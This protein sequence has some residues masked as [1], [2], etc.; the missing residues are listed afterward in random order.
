MTEWTYLFCYKVIKNCINCNLP[1]RV[2]ICGKYEIVHMC[3]CMCVCVC[4]S[5]NAFPIL[6][7][8]RLRVS[9]A[10]GRQHHQ[11]LGRCWNSHAYT[12]FTCQPSQ[13]ITKA[14]H[15]NFVI[16]I[17]IELLTNSTNTSI[18]RLLFLMRHLNHLLWQQRTYTHTH[19]YTYQCNM[20]IANFARNITFNSTQGVPRYGYST[21][22][23]H[24]Y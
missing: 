10:V 21:L 18:R 17:Q 14:L 24:F 9:I 23:E 5:T 13:E 4:L 8:R 19:T 16:N 7:M 12:A 20:T 22:C 3:M 11:H 6:I 1:V 2:E 15:S